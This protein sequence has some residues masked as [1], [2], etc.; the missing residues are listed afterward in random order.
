MIQLQHIFPQLS[1]LCL[2]D[3][4]KV[5]SL[6]ECK[7]GEVLVR[8]GDRADRAYFVLK[9]SAR[10]YY[11]KDG[12]DI[13]DWFAFEGDFISAIVSFFSEEASPHFIE[14]MEQSTLLVIPKGSIE[15]LAAKHRDFEIL[16]R[17]IITETMLQQQ[18]RL[19]AIL[20]QKAEE[21]YS[22]LLQLYPNITQKVKLTH[23]ASF[24]GI[25][26]ETLSRIRSSKGRI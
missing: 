22:E 12:K 16:Y 8:E 1:E 24:L 10:A 18:K 14:T 4:A 13:T 19:S 26:L 17:N 7:T 20:F 23:I 15:E 9:G 11:L 3:L 25:S 5:V 2:H 6:Q 21:R